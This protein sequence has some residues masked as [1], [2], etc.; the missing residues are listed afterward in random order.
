MKLLGNVFFIFVL[1]LVSVGTSHA[2][3]PLTN[4]IIER[5]ISSQQELSTWGDK[6]SKQL[7]FDESEGFPSSAA[8]MLAPVKSAGLYSELKGIVSKYGFANPEQWADASVRIIGAMGAIEIGDSMEG[9]DIQA[10]IS[11]IQNAD[12]MSPA[13]KQQ[14]IQMMQQSMGMVQQMASASD[15]DIA[16]VTPYMDKITTALE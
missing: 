13:Q 4:D 9:V 15:A 6:H 5:W 2:A 10:Q 8:E 3:E 16:A 11:E 7:K 14:M 12:G 1:L